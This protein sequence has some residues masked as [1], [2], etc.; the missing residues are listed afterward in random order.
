MTIALENYTNGA[1]IVSLAKS[2]ETLRRCLLN[3]LDAITQTPGSFD[4]TFVGLKNL[5][6]LNIAV[7][8]RVVVSKLNA[9]RLGVIADL[10]AT[11]LPPQSV[12]SVKFMGLEMLGAAAKNRERVWIS[13]EEAFQKSK[14]SIRKLLLNGRDVELYNFPLCAV[15]E[16]FWPICAK[17]VAAY[18]ARF[19]EKCANCRAQD[20]CG[21]IFA[22]TIRQ[23]AAD[24]KPIET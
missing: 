1:R 7:E 14:E 3:G 17:S 15:E 16:E 13:Y 4:E 24:V 21:G 22:G 11:E 23:A 9:A 2:R 20:A 18:K 5:A 19:T 12:K 6:R 8:L 10:I